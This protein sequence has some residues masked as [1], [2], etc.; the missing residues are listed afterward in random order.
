MIKAWS[1]LLSDLSQRQFFELLGFQ[2]LVMVLLSVG[3][4][5][6]GFSNGQDSFRSELSDDILS[7]NNSVLYRQGA[8]LT[9]KFALDISERDQSIICEFNSGYERKLGNFTW[10][11]DRGSCKW[12][13]DSV[14]EQWDDPDF[15]NRLKKP[16]V[17]SSVSN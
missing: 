2:V 16:E 11:Y 8:D 10:Q 1:E 9:R 4:F 17:N 3:M 6:V 7:E 5:E 13:D 15:E 12:V 14:S